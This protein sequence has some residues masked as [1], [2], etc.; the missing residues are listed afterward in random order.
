MVLPSPSKT[1]NFEADAQQDHGGRLHG[2]D[3][4]VD[5]SVQLTKDRVHEGGGVLGLGRGS[6]EGRA[7]KQRQTHKLGKRFLEEKL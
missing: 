4:G 1:D 6:R 5:G 7:G 3:G 2:L